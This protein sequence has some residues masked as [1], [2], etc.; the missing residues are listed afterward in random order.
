[1]AYTI[2][3]EVFEGP[4]DLLLHLIQK[5]KIDIYNIPIA[6]VTEQ[7]LNYL[8]SMQELD[9]EIASEF[10]LMSATLLAIKAKMLL[11]QTN[12]EEEQDEE[13]LDP[14]KE[15]VERLLEYQKYKNIAK[16]LKEKQI[17]Q[18]LSFSRPLDPVYYETILKNINPL[19][20]IAVDD[21]KE[22]VKLVLAEVPKE[23]V[24]K[25]IT[26]RVITVKDKMDYIERLVKEEPKGILFQELLSK[27]T[28]NLTIIVTFLALLE[29][30]HLKKVFIIQTVN[31][32]PLRIYP[33]TPQS[34]E[35]YVV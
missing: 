35:Q 17:Q 31:F 10:I 21:L 3:L 24:V 12:N 32:G 16:K 25:E 8:Q 15:L 1:M 11:P 13:N 29:L 7:Y 6:E 26:K 14:R 30:I 22:I 20:S 19:E 23:E 18:A 9:L 34:E 27:S 33:K 2:S 28:T 4:L 5:N